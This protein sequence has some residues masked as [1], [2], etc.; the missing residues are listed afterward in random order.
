MLNMRNLSRV[1]RTDTVETT[2]LDGIFSYIT[3]VLDNASP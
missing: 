1:Y 2:A 3:A